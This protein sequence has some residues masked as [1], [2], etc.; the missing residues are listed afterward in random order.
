MSLFYVTGISGSG[1]S[2]VCK[3]LAQR[4]YETHEVD[5]GLAG[6]YNNETHEEVERPTDPSQRTVEWRE[7]HTWKI[8]RKV[9]EDLATKTEEKPI[10]I[11]GTASNDNEFIDVFSKVVALVLDEKTL[12]HRIKTRKT[13]DFGKN[14]H[15]LTT[16]LE[17]Q[18]TAAADYK[19]SGAIL[20][21]ATQPVKQVADEVLD[22]TLST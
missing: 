14:P 20:I 3:E 18:K 19:K 7:H 13:G 8:P 11:C 16:I 10:F 9:L 4:G 6:F 17:W 2:E 21:D 5:D 1:K 12:V 22:V 15:E